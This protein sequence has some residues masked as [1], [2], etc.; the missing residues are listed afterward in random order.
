[1]I[2]PREPNSRAEMKSVKRTVT[3]RPHAALGRNPANI[4]AFWP[5]AS[6]AMALPAGRSRGG[7]ETTRW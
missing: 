3:L 2:R 4:K 6:R 7:R 5:N 1:M